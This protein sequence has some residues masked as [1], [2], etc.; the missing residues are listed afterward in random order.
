MPENDED[1]N[2]EDTK[3]TLKISHS[4]GIKAVE[5]TLQYFAQQGA[6]VMDLLFLRRLYDEAANTR[7]HGKLQ[8]NMHF[9]KKKK[10]LFAK[11]AT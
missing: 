11:S 6:S 10:P 5:T 8:D 3:P 4:E 1:V 9:F 2:V 7:V